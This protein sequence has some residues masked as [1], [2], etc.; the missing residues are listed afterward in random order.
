[1][2]LGIGGLKGTGIILTETQVPHTKSGDPARTIQVVRKSS[3]DNDGISGKIRQDD[4]D[5]GLQPE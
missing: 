5:V 1:M 4:E 3:I 2:S